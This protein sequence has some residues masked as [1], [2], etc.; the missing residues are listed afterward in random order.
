M[1]SGVDPGEVR[2][3]VPPRDTPIT[4]EEL[5]DAVAASIFAGWST[6]VSRATLRDDFAA[7]GLD[8]PGGDDAT[9]A[10]LHILED[11]D[12]TEPGFIVHTKGDNG[13]STLW[14]DRSTA[15]IVETRDEIL[16][17]ALDDALDFLAG[18]FASDNPAEWLWGKVHQVRFQHFLGTAGIDFLDLGNFPAP[19]GRFTVNPAGYSLNADSAGG[20]VFSGG[21]SKRFVAVLDPAGV[22]SVS[23]LP[24]GNNGNPCTGQSPSAC[25]AN[26]ASYNEIKPGVHYGDH[27]SGWIRGETFE[28]RVTRQAVAADTQE[29]IRY[30]PLQ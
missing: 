13:E 20:F 6:R 1:R 9:K 25:G 4:Q 11:I 2:P 26:A 14:D 29:L 8:A 30:V 24:G 5:D 3:D 10:L 19:G 27:V 18:I 28:Y 7:F 23:I 15:G 21:P 12:R 22:R 17:T 16:L